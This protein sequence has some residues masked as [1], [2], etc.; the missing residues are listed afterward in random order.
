M[1]E[2]YNLLNLISDMGSFFAALLSPLAILAKFLNKH[3]LY[4]KILRALYFV[5]NR[6]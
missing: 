2:V 5:K 4:N 1:R 6:K 3:Y